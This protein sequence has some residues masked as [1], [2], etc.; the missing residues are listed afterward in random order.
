MRHAKGEIR[1]GRIHKITGGGPWPC[2]TCTM[3]ADQAACLPPSKCVYRYD[4][5]GEFMAQMH[6]KGVLQHAASVLEAY[7]KVLGALAVTREGAGAMYRQMQHDPQSVL[8]WT[9]MLN[10]MKAV[11]TRYSTQLNRQVHFQLCRQACHLVDRCETSQAELLVLDPGCF[12]NQ[13]AV[14]GMNQQAKRRYASALPAWW[15]LP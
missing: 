4:I 1:G 9:R 6:Q 13:K 11:C 7:L 15:K 14:G 2:S 10:T 8:S 12:A 5:F 3:L